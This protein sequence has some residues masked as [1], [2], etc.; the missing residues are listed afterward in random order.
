[1]NVKSDI[2]AW[3]FWMEVK[4]MKKGDDTPV[5]FTRKFYGKIIV[6]T[7]FKCLCREDFL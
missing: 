7:T 5:S 4:D 3:E 6:I 2:T 1:M